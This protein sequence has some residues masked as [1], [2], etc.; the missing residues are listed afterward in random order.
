MS[1]TMEI[2]LPKTEDQFTKYLEAAQLTEQV[3]QNVVGYKALVLEPITSKAQYEELK[4]LKN[5]N[6]VKVRTRTVEVCEAGRAEANRISAEWLSVQKKYVGIVKETEDLF[7]QRLAEWEEIDKARQRE[8]EAEKKLAFREKIIANAGIQATPDQYKYLTDVEFQA[9]FDAQ[10]LLIQQAKEKAEADKKAAELLEAQKAQ[11]AADALKNAHR[12]IRYKTMLS[13]GFS[14]S[15]VSKRFI[16][17]IV[18]YIALKIEETDVY[19]VSDEAFNTLITESQAVITEAKAKRD[20][21]NAAALAKKAEDDARAKIAIEDAQKKADE[22]AQK[23]AELAAE[24][25]RKAAEEA[26]RIAEIK[27]KALAPDKEKLAEFVASIKPDYPIVATDQGLAIVAR[28]KHLFT[29]LVKDLND[30]IAKL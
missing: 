15:E 18:N 21:D 6:I 4:S 23:R 10:C 24:N 8:E 5:K 28:A 2:I 26:A 3:F 20:A 30:H 13:I 17:E 12:D 19:D 22:E 25:A 1:Q 9:F 7:N 16:C 27:R 29:I 11:A 14:Y